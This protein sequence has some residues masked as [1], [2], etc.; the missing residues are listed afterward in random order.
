MA[1]NEAPALQVIGKSVT[2]RGYNLSEVT[3]DPA[4]MERAWVQVATGDQ[5][6]QQAGNETHDGI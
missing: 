1:S 2:I 4:R 5:A 3:T 6:E